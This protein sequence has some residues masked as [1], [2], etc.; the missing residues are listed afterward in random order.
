MRDGGG[1]QVNTLR[2]RE[3]GGRASSPGDGLF[4]ENTSYRR[5]RTRLSR[6]ISTSPESSA[7]RDASAIGRKDSIPN[8]APPRPALF[9]A[10]HSQTLAARAKSYGR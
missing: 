3:Y 7:L 8:F 9:R 1:A 5:G 6:D 2:M 10:V 4:S